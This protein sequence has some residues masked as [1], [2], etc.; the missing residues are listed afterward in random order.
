[1]Y[2]R[3]TESSWKQLGIPIAAV[4]GFVVFQSLVGHGISQDNAVRAAESSSYTD[5][6]VTERHTFM[7]GLQ[8][9]AKSDWVMFDVTAKDATGTQRTFIVCDGLFKAATIRFK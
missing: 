7:V 3:E 9:C 1:M 8:G 4:I 5:V 2:G 6:M